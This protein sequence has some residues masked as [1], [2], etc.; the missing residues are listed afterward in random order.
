MNKSEN[1]FMRMMD[2]FTHFL[3][4]NVIWIISSLALVTF[5]PATTAM[6]AVV[7]KWTTE[8]IDAG[9]FSLYVSK[10][11]ENF[12]KSF[13]IGLIWIAAG[14]VLYVDGTILFQFS[15]PGHIILISL[16]M[17]AGIIYLF[18]TCYIFLVLVNYELSLFHTIKNALFL[19]V[20]KI[21]HTL[22]YLVVIGMTMIIVYFFPFFLLIAGSL[23]AFIIYQIFHKMI[24]RLDSRLAG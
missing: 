13:V 6:F 10:F 14:V 19:S 22:L 9:L 12:R 8:G 15:F 11:R 1:T 7:R 20:S 5:F 2:I 16:L 4:L 23:Q 18:T 24:Y 17:F 3:L 21:F